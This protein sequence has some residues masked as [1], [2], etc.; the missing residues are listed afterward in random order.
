MPKD[1]R[2]SREVPPEWPGLLARAERLVPA[3]LPD[4]YVPKWPLARLC[5]RANRLGNESLEANCYY[6]FG[7]IATGM[8]KLLQ[9]PEF[10][11]TITSTAARIMVGV[12]L[13]TRLPT[14]PLNK[15]F[16]PRVGDLFHYKAWQQSFLPVAGMAWKALS[17]PE[18]TLTDV[19]AASMSFRREVAKTPA[20]ITKAPVFFDYARTQ[21]IAARQVTANSVSGAALAYRLRIV[22]AAEGEDVAGTPLTAE[23]MQAAWD[24]TAFMGS[25]RSRLDELQAGYGWSEVDHQAVFDAESL[26]VPPLPLNECPNATQLHEAR[27]TCPAIQ[28]GGLARE[29]AE[30]ILPE[31][32]QTA[33]TLVP[34]K[35][36]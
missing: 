14:V 13:R 1:I 9:Q 4:K 11:A 36:V 34:E 19:L 8:A 16:V 33:A 17:V 12:A 26:N 6:G 10:R 30:H 35:I 28:A 20:S 5:L 25:A 22:G 21:L 32:I 24:L 15:P 3:K 23:T 2:H 27:L 7:E 29:M 18:R 31:I